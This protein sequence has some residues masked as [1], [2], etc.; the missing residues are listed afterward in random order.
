[1]N[2]QSQDGVFHANNLG[3][4]H[5]WILDAYPKFVNTLKS[6]TSTASATAIILVNDMDGKTK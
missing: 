3:M 2:Q 1:M 6:D 4:D 5:G